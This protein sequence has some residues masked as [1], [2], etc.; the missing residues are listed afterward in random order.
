MTIDT[1][2]NL[3]SITK[4]GGTIIVE[5]PNEDDDLLT[6]SSGYSKIARLPAHVNS[7]NKK[8][9]SLLLNNLNENTYQV[10]FIPVQR[11]GFYNYI[12]WLRYNEKAK[13]SSDDYITRNE[14][15]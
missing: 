3:F 6:L 13:I 7:F 15:S 11:Y 8:T 2:K 10:E 5:V 1:L 4:S 12:E 9:L 14:K